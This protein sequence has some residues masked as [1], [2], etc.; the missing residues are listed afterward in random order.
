RALPSLGDQ[1]HRYTPCNVTYAI[2]QVS[3][4]EFPGVGS[5]V[6]RLPPAKATVNLPC[7][8]SKSLPRQPRTARMT[9]SEGTPRYP[10]RMARPCEL[11]LSAPAR[12]AWSG[13]TR[14]CSGLRPKSSTGHRL[15]QVTIFAP[16]G[17]I[18]LQ[19]KA[20]K[21]PRLRR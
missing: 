3:F 19:D 5:V 18:P 1:H 20:Q 2:P 6:K 15:A 21:R 13:E 4:I 12:I 9:Y 11:Q 8:L 17:R 7:V 14:S 10:R 16:E